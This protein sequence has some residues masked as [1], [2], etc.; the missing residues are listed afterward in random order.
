MHALSLINCRC[1]SDVFHV[2]KHVLNK[3]PHTGAVI[4]S[5]HI[6]VVYATYIAPYKGS[7]CRYLAVNNSYILLNFKVKKSSINT[8]F[9]NND[10]IIKIYAPDLVNF[11]IR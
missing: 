11:G 2:C 7:S 9:V 6:D 1:Y 5:P 3:Y 4:I 10:N 8:R